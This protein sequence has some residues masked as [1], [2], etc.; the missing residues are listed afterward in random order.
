MARAAK[1]VSSIVVVGSQSSPGVGTNPQKFSSQLA[2]QRVPD[3]S[4]LVDGSSTR[5]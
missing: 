2:H 3:S 5:T 4:F 1:T